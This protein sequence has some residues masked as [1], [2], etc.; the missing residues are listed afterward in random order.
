MIDISCAGNVLCGVVNITYDAM[1]KIMRDNFI[2]DDDFIELVFDVGLK[3]M[4]RK[5]EIVCFV[6][7]S[8]E[9]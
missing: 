2:K 9:V 6:E 8:E 5:R 7:S 1:T 3:G 4:V